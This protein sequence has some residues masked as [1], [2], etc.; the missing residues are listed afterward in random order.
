MIHEAGVVR[1]A[2]AHVKAELE[3]TKGLLDKILPIAK[4]Q[5]KAQVPGL[6]EE[7]KKSLLEVKDEMLETL[8][9]QNVSTTL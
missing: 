4:L 3:T 2:N 7:T 5:L 8:K 1:L 6:P 9:N